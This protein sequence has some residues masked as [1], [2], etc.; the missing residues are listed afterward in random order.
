MKNLNSTPLEA[1]VAAINLISMLQDS[2]IDIVQQEFDPWPIKVSA[3]MDCWSKKLRKIACVIRVIQT[4]RQRVEN[5]KNNI[6]PSK[7]RPRKNATKDRLILHFTEEERDKAESLLINAIQSISF[8]REVVQL[9]KMG[10][11]SES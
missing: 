11:F 4:L 3:K 10:I 8:E 5:K 6:L 9:A 7:L 1:D 2:A